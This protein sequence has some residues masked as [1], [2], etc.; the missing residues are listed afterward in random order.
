MAAERAAHAGRPTRLAC[1]LHTAYMHV[2]TLFGQERGQA[3]CSGFAGC[4][5]R[6]RCGRGRAK[7]GA[8]ETQEAERPRSTQPQIAAHARS[9]TGVRP[10]RRGGW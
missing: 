7:E 8:G 3:A 5:R 6:P 10:L 2:P 9:S 4:E 1:A